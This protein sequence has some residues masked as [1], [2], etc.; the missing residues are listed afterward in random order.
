M[1]NVGRPRKTEGLDL[2]TLDEAVR[3]A[4]EYLRLPKPPFTKRTL[5]NK[6][7]MGLYQRYGTYRIPQVDWNEVKRSLHW[8]RKIG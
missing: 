1:R 6:I 3:R 7:S 2:V 4:Q 8:R 5:Q